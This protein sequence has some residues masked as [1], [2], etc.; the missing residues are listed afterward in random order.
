MKK[1]LIC[2]ISGQ[3]GSYLAELLLKKGYLV[4]G[5]SRDAQTNNFH[6]LEYLGIKKEVKLLSMSLN[7]FRSVM[8]AIKSTMPDEIY[9]LAGQSSVGMSFEMPIDTMESICSG[10]L[11]LLEAIR[12]LGNGSKFYNA[13][14]GEC[15]GENN[16]QK[17]TE[18]DSFKPTSPYGVAKAAAFWATSNYRDAYGIFASFLN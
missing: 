17:S 11:N 13:G 10:T 6:R 8:Q 15:F 18:D 3:D 1:A 16:G 7:D 4:T 5:T 9:N 2:G 14:S 12:F